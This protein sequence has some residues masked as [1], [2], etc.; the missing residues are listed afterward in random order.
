MKKDPE[1]I[2]KGAVTKGPEQKTMGET[3]NGISRTT[4]PDKINTTS[5]AFIGDAVYSVYVRRHVLQCE[6]SDHDK[7]H[8]MAV[9][10]V[11]AESQAAV[12]KA[13]M[14]EPDTLSAELKTLVKRARNHRSH[15]KP[16]H[17]DAVTYKWST[18][19]EALI[20]Y[21]YLKE[22]TELMEDLIGRAIGITEM[23]NEGSMEK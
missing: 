21:L 11:R 5:L 7:M 13:L 14:D 23:K 19:F 2:R 10:Y 8:R 18:A 4:D 20:G 6:S 3:M 17:A 12:I 22:E 1:V 15:S 9:S 16:R